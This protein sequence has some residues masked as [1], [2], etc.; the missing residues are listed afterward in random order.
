[1]I[2]ARTHSR[3]AI[4]IQGSLITIEAYTAARLPKIVIIE[5]RETPFEESNDR[6]KTALQ[7]HPR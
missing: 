7:V 6:V 4:G 3:G 5:V 2:S 1:M